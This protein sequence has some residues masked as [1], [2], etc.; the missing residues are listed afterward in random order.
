LVREDDV[1]LLF[2]AVVA[3][4][5]IGKVLGGVWDARNIR[6]LRDHYG[7]SDAQAARLYW[8]ARE[9]GFGAAHAAAVG[10]SGTGPDIRSAPLTTT[11]RLGLRPNR[12]TP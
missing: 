4:V 1:E 7:W 8:A 12:P 2:G 9:H 10:R 3:W 5:A 6:R 11:V